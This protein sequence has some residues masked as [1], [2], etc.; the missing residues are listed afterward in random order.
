MA[1]RADG[2]CAA[3]SMISELEPVGSGNMTE[4]S[5]IWEP[6]QGIDMPCAEIS[7]QYHRAHKLRVVM[8]FSRVKASGDQDLEVMFAGVIG[9]RW[10]DEFHG[11]VVHPMARPLPKC[12]SERWGRWVFPLLA[13]LDSSWLASYQNLPGTERRQHFALI[14]MNDL[15]DVIAPPDVVAKWVPAAL[16]AAK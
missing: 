7:F 1:S 16:D 11:S 6:A 2:Y 14:S 12:R 8:H 9:I 4:R 3:A 13:D 5:I 15:V 10:A